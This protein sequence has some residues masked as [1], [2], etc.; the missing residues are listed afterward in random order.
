GG[1]ART[2]HQGDVVR[3]VVLLAYCG[4]RRGH[5]SGLT[6]GRFVHFRPS[7]VDLRVDHGHILG[8]PGDLVAS[9]PNAPMV[10]GGSTVDY[11]WRNRANCNPERSGPASPD[12][13][14]TDAE[15]TQSTS[16]ARN[17]RDT[18]PPDP[19]IVRQK[20]PD[21]EPSGRGI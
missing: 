10:N 5:R 18:E 1:G 9:A 14:E 8:I 16:P 12:G 13:S 4:V 17:G 7:F 6:T 3:V 21:T 19:D 11:R 2:G 15:H 20:Q